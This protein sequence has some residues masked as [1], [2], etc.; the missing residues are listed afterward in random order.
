MEENGSKWKQ[1]EAN[2]SKRKQKKTDAIESM[3]K[4]TEAKKTNG[5][6]IFSQTQQIDNFFDKS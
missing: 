1:M 5:K 6:I 4:Q 2:G 3:Q